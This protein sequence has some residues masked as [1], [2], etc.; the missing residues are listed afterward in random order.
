MK[1][2]K[3]KCQKACLNFKVIYMNWIRKKTIQ[4][5][6]FIL[7]AIGGFL[8]WRFVGCESGT[9]MIKSV[10]Y[11]STLWGAAMGYLVGDL[12]DGILIKIKKRND[13]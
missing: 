5:V 12:I 11:W 2:L 10:W 3:T 9:C 8:Y 1:M 13:K 4:I 6:F 7:G